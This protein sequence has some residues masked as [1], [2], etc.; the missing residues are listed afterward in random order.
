MTNSAGL[1]SKNC[2]SDSQ[3]KTRDN[4]NTE[5]KQSRFLRFV[6]LNYHVRIR[7]SSMITFLWDCLECLMKISRWNFPI[8]R[9]EFSGVKFCAKIEEISERYCR[10]KESRFYW[11]ETKTK[12]SKAKFR[13]E[14][15][16][17]IFTFH[18]LNEKNFSR[19][20][21]WFMNQCTSEDQQ[22]FVKI[23]REFL[24]WSSLNSFLCLT[25]W[26]D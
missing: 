6:L 2:H 16:R 11:F 1:S 9:K 18:W 4:Q 15:D 8:F 10:D 17:S 12:N 21:V 20:S 19:P 22:F 23:C 7:V 24:D 13:R 3:R 26:I 25:T 14:W 5:R